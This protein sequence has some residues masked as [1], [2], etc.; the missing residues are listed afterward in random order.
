MHPVV[1]LALHPETPIVS[2]L[3]FVWPPRIV[4]AAL[5]LERCRLAGS[6]KEAAICAARS[7]ILTSSQQVTYLNNDA[8]TVLH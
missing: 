4:A 5:R 3:E 1:Q 2:D 6:C 8:S 7:G